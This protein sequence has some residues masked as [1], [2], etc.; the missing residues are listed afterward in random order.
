MS[1]TTETLD[2]DTIV[3]AA[4]RLIDTEGV[5]ALTM[6]R[7]SIELGV[8]QPALYRHLDGINDLW[9]SLGLKT[10]ADLAQDLAEASVGW[11]GTD[12]VRAIA[13]AWRRYGQQHPGCYRSTDRFP[14]AGDPE[15]ESTVE[16]VIEVLAMALRGFD[17]SNED[18]VHGARAIRS[19]LHGFVTFELGDGHPPPHHPDRSYDALVD[20][21]CLGIEAQASRQSSHRVNNATDIEIGK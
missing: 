21:L 4:A 11:S 17:L 1:L 18:A 2:A 10:R 15:L 12:A 5:D 19:A 14:V 9:R 7:V 8:T 6:A 20:L 13:S 3:R 16:R